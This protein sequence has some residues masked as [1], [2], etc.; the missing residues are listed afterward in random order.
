MGVK[1]LDEGVFDPPWPSSSMT[2]LR[3]HK[4]SA[5]IPRIVVQKYLPDSPFTMRRP[6]V[7]MLLIALSDMTCAPTP[8]MFDV[9]G[10][11]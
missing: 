5:G 4:P 7:A 10:A 8:L 6:E 1:M 9:V 2:E 3:G 11:Q